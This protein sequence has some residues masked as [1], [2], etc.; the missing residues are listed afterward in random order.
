MNK[1][2][3]LFPIFILLAASA[4]SFTSEA[5]RD[6]PDIYNGRKFLQKGM[7]LVDTGNNDF[8]VENFIF[9]YNSFSLADYLPGKIK[10]ACRLYKNYNLA[11]DVQKCEEWRKKAELLIESNHS[12]MEYITLAKA[13]IHFSRKQYRELLDMTDSYDNTPEE[14]K[15]QIQC[16]RALSALKCGEDYSLLIGEIKNTADRLCEM[17]ED[18]EL[19]DISALSFLYYNLGYLSAE[20]GNRNKAMDY[21]ER[22]IKIDKEISNYPAVAD[23]LMLRANIHFKRKEYSDA[24]AFYERSADIYTLLKN[25]KKLKIIADRIQDIKKLTGE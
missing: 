24:L 7:Y 11:G 4:C 25:D 15:G 20:K 21:L 8:A 14:I 17:R 2:L 22:A 18:D 13:E 1:K 3:I 19:P 12:G 6:N 10:A 23:N 9:A 5:P 16:Y